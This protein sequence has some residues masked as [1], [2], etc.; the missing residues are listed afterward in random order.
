[1]AE[2]RKERTK[3]PRKMTHELKKKIISLIE[4]V[5]RRNKSKAD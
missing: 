3:K 5:F 4:E 2:L 1:M